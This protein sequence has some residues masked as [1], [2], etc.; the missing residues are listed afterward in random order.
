M[1]QNTVDSRQVNICSG[2]CKRIPTDCLQRS[3]STPAEHKTW[4]GDSRRTL[5]MADVE[6]CQTDCPANT[7]GANRTKKLKSPMWC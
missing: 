4:D 1:C 5:I 2:E 7:T 3:S 6:Q